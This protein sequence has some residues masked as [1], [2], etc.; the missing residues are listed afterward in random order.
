MDD[1]KEKN[2]KVYWCQCFDVNKKI[3]EKIKEGSIP[4][5]TGEVCLK[6]GYKIFEEDA[7]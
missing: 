3:S 2:K 1:Q 5:D 7:K 6:C 4:R